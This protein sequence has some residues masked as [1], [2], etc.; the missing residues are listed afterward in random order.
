MSHGSGLELCWFL[1]A[2]AK[3]LA[4]VTWDRQ[5]QIWDA[6]TGDPITPPVPLGAVAGRADATLPV[7]PL[8]LDGRPVGDLTLLAQLLGGHEVDASAGLVSVSGATLQ[9]A[10]ETLRRRYPADFGRTPQEVLAWHWHELEECERRQQ[11]FAAVWHLERLRSV[12]G[13][14]WM[15]HDRLAHLHAGLGEWSLS[16]AEFSRAIEQ[17]ADDSDVWHFC[18]LAQLALNDRAGYQK[19][20]AKLVELFGK[21]ADPA[22]ALSL[23]WS[24]ALAPETGVAAP[25]LDQLVAKIVADNPTNHVQNRMLGAILLRCGRPDEAL[26]RLKQADVSWEPTP[27]T[28]LLLALAHHRLGNTEESRRWLDKAT[29]LMDSRLREKSKVAAAA[30]RWD[31]LSWNQRLTLELLWDE[32]Q[33]LLKPDKP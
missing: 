21:G 2:D 17:G 22:T 11:R 19:T 28:W 7:R 4:T 30:F 26:H 27:M 20:C 16:A 29:P 33:S 5:L 3:R 9:N 15:F 12:Q 14:H 8:A 25:L 1:G 18:A 6:T 32:T 10:W 13:D 24:C 23:A 31:Q